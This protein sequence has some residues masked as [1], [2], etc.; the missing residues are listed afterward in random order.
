[1]IVDIAPTVIHEAEN[2]GFPGSDCGN[3][4]RSPAGPH[5]APRTRAAAAPAALRH[6]RMPPGRGTRR[7]GDAAMPVRCAIDPPWRAGA[8]LNS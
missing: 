2:F 7:R 1:M 8:L 3:A 6:R 4:Q 5:R